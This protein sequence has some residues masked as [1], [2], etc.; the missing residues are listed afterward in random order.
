MKYTLHTLALATGLF[1]FSADTAVAQKTGLFSKKKKKEQPK[2]EKKEEDKYADLIKKCSKSEGLFTIYRDTVSG[3][4]Y[5]E[6]KADQLNK[7]YIYFNH[8]VNAPVESG[9]FTGS[10]GDSKIIRFKKEF[11]KMW[12]IQENTNLLRRKQQDL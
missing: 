4:S 3:K 9:Y 7:E 12:V 5:L 10:F 2:E 6:V 1:F 11:E 8:I